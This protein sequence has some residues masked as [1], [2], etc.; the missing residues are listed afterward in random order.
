MWPSCQPEMPRRPSADERGP[1]GADTVCHSCCQGAHEQHLQPRRE[2]TVS[3]EEGATGPDREQRRQGQ[4]RCRGEA[5]AIEPGQQVGKQR[6][7]AGED[8]AEEGRDA[9]ADRGG[10]RRDG[11]FCTSERRDRT[12]L[13][14]ME[15]PSATKLATPR[16]RMTVDESAAPPTPDTTARVVMIRSL[17]SRMRSGR[18][19]PIRRTA[20]HGRPTGRIV[21][22]LLGAWPIPGC[23]RFRS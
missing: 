5:R 15:K 8:E 19:L 22:H 17:A 3:G 21:D 6:N 20:H 2:P 11:P 7:E 9:M 18:Y 1:E 16:M 10:Q 4:R 23:S 12:L 14:S 13:A